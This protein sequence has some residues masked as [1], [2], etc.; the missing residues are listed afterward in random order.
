MVL[1]LILENFEERKKNRKTIERT[2][3]RTT[4]VTP[5]NNNRSNNGG[6]GAGNDFLS[7]G[8]LNQETKA[9]LFLLLACIWPLWI[10]A[11]FGSSSPSTVQEVPQV[12]GNGDLVHSPTSVVA[13]SSSGGSHKLNLRSMLDRVDIMGYGPTHPRLAIVIVGEDKEYVL[14]SVESVFRNTDLNRVFLICVVM[15]GHDSDQGLIDELHK[16]DQGSVPH[17]HGL[18]PD[19]HILG[20]KHKDDITTAGEDDEDSKDHKENE[21]GRKIH[22]M[23]NAEKQGLSASRADA[24]EFVSLLEKNHEK[25]GLKSPEEDLILLLLESGAQLLDRKWLAPVT[26]ALIVPPPILP[27]SKYDNKMIA[28]KLANAVALHDQEQQGFGK[29]WSFDE[30]FI[31]TLTE[32]SADDINQSSGQ[33][34][35]TPAYNGAALALRLDTYRNLP[36]QDLSLE[37]SW[38]ANL[39]LALNLWLCGDGIDIFVDAEVS[40]PATGTGDDSNNMPLEPSEIARFAAAWMDDTTASK[41]LQAYSTKITRL[42][43]ETKMMHA[44]QDSPTFPKDLQKKCRS[45][46]W[47]AKDVNSDITHIVDT[48]IGWHEHG[49]KFHAKQQEQIQHPKL[50]VKEKEVPVK[51]KKEEEDKPPEEPVAEDKKDVPS[52]EM[53]DGAPADKAVEKGDDENSIPNLAQNHGQKPKTPLRQ[54]NLDIVQKAKPVDISYVD[55]TDGFKEFPHKGARDVNG[56]W[57]YVHDETFLKKNPPKFEYEAEAEKKACTNRD[58]NYKMMIKRVF[59]DEEY[60]K[61]RNADGNKRDKIFCLVYTIESGHNKIPNIL[62]TWG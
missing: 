2:K 7:D 57:G 22:V 3:E 37:E 62:E 38:P 45:F 12:D 19:I 41:F 35:P 49:K 6:N 21:H 26:S 30:K 60:N 42:D 58:N 9:R 48:Q 61:Q 18:R 13:S 53:E 10:F 11:L 50:M 14:Q 29:R 23:F 25:A 36:A 31:P 8:G 44:R 59:V 56:Q 16:I 33:S 47:Y 24:V 32:A 55:V 43:W 17:W 46:D 52:S 51:V 1:F 34:Y 20:K 4:M 28:M 39:E 5:K 27:H 15:D 54:T 40:S